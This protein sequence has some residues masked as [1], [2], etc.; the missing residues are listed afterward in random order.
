M[1][2]HFLIAKNSY[3]LKKNLQVGSYFFKS[4]PF[5]Y[6]TDANGPSSIVFVNFVK[7]NKWT[8]LLFAMF[9]FAILVFPEPKNTNILRKIFPATSLSVNVTL[10]EC[11]KALS[12]PWCWKLP[13]FKTIGFNFF[14]EVS[15]DIPLL[16]SC[17]FRK[18]FSLFP[19]SE[20]WWFKKCKNCYWKWFDFQIHISWFDFQI[21]IS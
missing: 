4:Y 9:F 5:S 7:K 21:H 12:V 11:Q 6:I 14:V 8:F 16:D 2:C 10:L 3:F 19:V 13:F 1:Q 15:I 17:W 18:F 20:F